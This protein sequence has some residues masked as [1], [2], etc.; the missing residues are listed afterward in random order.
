MSQSYQ[1][2]VCRNLFGWLNREL[3]MYVVA[4]LMTFV[5][6]LIVFLLTLPGCSFS[7]ELF[8][9]GQV[10]AGADQSPVAGAKVTLVLMNSDE[11][12][13]VTDSQGRWVLKKSLNDIWFESGKDKKQWLRSDEFKLRIEAREETYFVPCPRVAVQKSG[14]AFGFVMAVLEVQQEPEVRE[15][16]PEFQPLEAVK[17]CHYDN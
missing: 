5:L 3:R 6:V 14:D 17:P 7:Y 12:T 8:L 11:V 2:S 9:E 10:L 1:R 16:L 4:K 13:C 15:P